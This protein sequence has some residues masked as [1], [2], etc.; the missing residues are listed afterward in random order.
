M[1]KTLLCIALYST[2]VFSDEYPWKTYCPIGGDN[3]NMIGDGFSNAVGYWVDSYGFAQCN[4]T[5]F[6]AFKLEQDGVT[7]FN[8]MYLG[9]KWGDGGKWG[10]AA[11]SITGSEDIVV[12]KFPKN[13]T[14]FTIFVTIA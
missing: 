12:D 11:K 5:S 8:N 7:G 14:I 1:K 10:T 4:C 6:A 13:L 2:G 3:P 9:T